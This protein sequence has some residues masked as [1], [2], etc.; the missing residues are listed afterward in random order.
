[1]DSL[2][3]KLIKNLGVAKRFGKFQQEIS[4]YPLLC[5]FSARKTAGENL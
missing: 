2:T 3:F 4:F 1:M 5:G